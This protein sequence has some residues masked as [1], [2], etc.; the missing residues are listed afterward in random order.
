VPALPTITA[1]IPRTPHVPQEHVRQEHVGAYTLSRKLEGGLRADVWLGLPWGSTSPEDAVLIKLFF[2]HEPGPALDGLTREL[3]LA[4]TLEHDNILRTLQVGSESGRRFSVSEYL[5]GVTLG[6]VLRRASVA[7]VPLGDAVVA[8]VLLALI[9]VLVYAEAQAA[10]APQKLLV[11]HLVAAD[12]VFITYDGEVKLLGFKSR[13]SSAG[14]S[15]KG[16]DTE[17]YDAGPAAVDA[18]L[19]EHATAELRAVLSAAK[20]PE[21]LPRDRPR[22]VGQAL[23]RWQTEQLGSDGRAELAALMSVLLPRTRLEQRAWLEADIARGCSAE[24]E[25]RPRNEEAP[26]VSGFRRMER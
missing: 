1:T 19:S 11:H 8:R 23:E 2:P 24:H 10:S 4:R 15:S 13:L 20:D 16:A 5:E 25:R 9:R 22:Q 18:L 3:A 21:I 14:R 7:S 12:D 26:P 6:A 17:R